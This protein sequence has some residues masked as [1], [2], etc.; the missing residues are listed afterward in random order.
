MLSLLLAPPLVAG[1]A[2]LVSPPSRNAVDRFLPAFR[3]GQTPRSS[4]SCNCGSSRKGCDGLGPRESANG[5]PCLWFSQGCS[6]G[7]EAC[8]GVGSHSNA[9]LCNA[10]TLPTL[11]K[12]AWTMNRWA[13]EGSVNDTY[14]YNPWRRPGSAPV[15]DACGQAGG[16]MPWHAGPGVAVFA[17]TSFA[18]FGQLGSKVLPPAP[19]GTV[20]ESGASVEVSWGL[21]FNHGGGYQYRLC[22]A[23]EPLT[24]ACFMRTPLPFNRGKQALMWNNGTRLPIRG[25]WVDEGTMPIGSTWAMNPVPRIDFDAA[26]SG[27]PRGWSGCTLDA[28]GDPVGKGCRQFDPPCPW[29][30]GWYAQPGGPTHNIDVEGACSGDWTGGVIVDEV[31]VPSDLPPGDYVLGWRWDCEESTQVW[32]NCADVTIVKPR[33]EQVSSHV[34]STS[35]VEEDARA[36]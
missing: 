4:C 1:H 9:S 17:N 22:P 3:R 28:K 32:S 33:A 27:Q 25:T 10:S 6:I 12:H 2:A 36:S 19:S 34:S 21:R 18:R 29:D 23:S 8:T 20:W 31:I 16:T 26:S 24:E 14:R 5:Q 15:V 13:V 7:C 30:D 11:P 35:A